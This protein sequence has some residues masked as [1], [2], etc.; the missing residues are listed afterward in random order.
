MYSNDD[1]EEKNDYDFDD[2]FIVRDEDEES[3]DEEDEENFKLVD[4]RR[5]RNRIIRE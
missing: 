5:E 4:D 1:E 3:Y 2:G